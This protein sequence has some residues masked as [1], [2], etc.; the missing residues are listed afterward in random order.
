MQGACRLETCP[1]SR[2]SKCLEGFAPPD[3]CPNYVPTPQPEADAAGGEESP[4]PRREV[5][6]LPIGTVLTAE[7]SYEITRG[8]FARIIVCAGEQRSGKT[9]LLASIYDAFQHGPVGPLEFAG[10]DTLHGFERRC[11]LSRFAS[12]LERPD[13]ERTKPGEG[14]HFLHLRVWDSRDAKTVDLLLGDMSGEL[15]KGMR[16]STEECEKHAFV[17]RAHD[18]I[19][20]LDGRKVLEGAHAE[21][22]AHASGLV[23]ALL[24]AEVLGAHSRV[25]LLSTKVD[26]LAADEHAAARERLTTIEEQFRSTFGPRVR[27]VLCTRG[28][29]RPDV[30]DPIGIYELLDAWVKSAPIVLPPPAAHVE[31]VSARPFDAFAAVRRHESPWRNSW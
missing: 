21:V 25:T 4:K 7:D 5:V 24:D 23:R 1:F 28:A 8:A 18:F 30:G 14:F 20:L 17:G 31:L 27:E 16:D 29:A 11:H 15:Y 10:C 26:L 9:T 6:R 2:T 12:G 19:V 13:T 3:G 22:Y